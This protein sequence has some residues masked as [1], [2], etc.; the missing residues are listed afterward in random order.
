M[1]TRRSIVG[2]ERLRAIFRRL[3]KTVRAELQGAMNR[4]GAEMATRARALVPVRSGLLRQSIRVIPFNRGGIGVIVQAGG[5]LTTDYDVLS[6]PYD[7]AM[8][9]ELG[10]QEMLASPFFYPAYRHLRSGIKRKITAAV[11]VAVSKAVK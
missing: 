6:R 7:Y 9:Q 10:T 11:K 8:A 2:R 5:E 1:P 3:P 4:A